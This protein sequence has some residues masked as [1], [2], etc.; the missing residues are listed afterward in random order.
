MHTK[1]SGR[2]NTKIVIKILDILSVSEG[3]FC[4]F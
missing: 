4:V 1:G 3:L 2:I